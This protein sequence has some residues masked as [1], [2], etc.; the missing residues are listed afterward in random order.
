M[1]DRSFQE[2]RAELDRLGERLDDPGAHRDRE[3]IKGRIIELY[4]Q[5]D[6]ELAALGAI[7]D[8]VLS[9]IGR[10]KAV[11]QGEQDVQDSGEAP[12]RNA[13]RSPD[14]V[15]TPPPTPVSPVLERAALEARVSSRDAEADD[16]GS[17]ARDVPVRSDHLGAS[18]F[19]ERGW[20]QIAAGDP[21]AAESSLRRALQL[22]PH[23]PSTEALLGWAM[24][25][26]E[27]YDEALMVFNRVLERDSENALA[28]VNVGYICLKKG[29]WG[30]AIEHLTRAVK[31]DNDRKATL[32]AHFYLGL[33]YLDREMYED[34]C[35]FFRRAVELGPNLVEAYYE[36]GRAAW[37][38]DDFDGA[39]E[40]WRNGF[41]ANKF[42][43]WGKRCGAM[44]T[45]VD[46]GG[47]PP[48]T[49]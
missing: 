13:P 19:I 30:E 41:A 46:A 43:A 5:V 47:S 3:A 18:T 17:T 10:W 14:G 36:L 4:K 26:Q 27:K 11:T 25:A 20:S 6:R 29:I 16:A 35:G 28:R 15:T 37:F 34:A 9:L 44:L 45:Q 33:V 23:E 22:A 49:G 38:A 42:N 39:R 24:V 8:D 7:K 12:A 31:L 32:Y 40:A 1:P 2:F 21:V 48:R